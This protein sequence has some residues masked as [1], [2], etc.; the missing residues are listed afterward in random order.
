MPIAPTGGGR[1][2]PRHGRTR[3]LALAAASAALAVPL[4]TVPS[5]A[6]R[7]TAPRTGFELSGGARWT[8]QA[9]EASL[10]AALARHGD[11]VSVRRIGTTAQGRPLRLVRLGSTEPDALTVLLVC[12]QHGDEPAARE[13]C[14]STVRDLAHATDARTRAFLARTEVLVVPTANPDGLAAGTRGNGDGVDVNRDHLALRSA[15]ARALAGVV[16]DHEPDVIEDLHEYGATVPYYDKDLLVLWPRNPNTDERLHDEAHDLAVDRVRPAALDA[17]FST[18][19]YGVWTDPDT[20]RPVRRTAGDG[21]ER[22]LRNVAGL[23]HAVALL[24]ESRTDALSAEERADPALNDRRRVASQLVALK[25]LFRYADERRAGIAAATAH[26]RAAGSDDAGP[27]VLGGADDEAPAPGD[28]L[29]DPPC[30]YR[31]TKEQFARVRD[32]LALHAVTSRPDGDG[33][34]VPLRQPAR[35]L[36]PLLLDGRA[37]YHLTSGQ[38]DTAC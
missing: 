5:D 36:I 19:V 21:Q 31:L 18:G 14:L 33:V 28:T 3:N 34:Y 7:T 26:S 29:T 32:E 22:V 38:P 13:A 2:P 27:V 23:K 20:G 35:K 30:G 10:L 4:L 17:G 8:T 15:E 25:A 24:V 12:G 16:R 9:E 37:A 6:A 1:R 11:R